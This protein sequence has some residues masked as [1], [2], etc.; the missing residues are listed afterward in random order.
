MALTRMDRWQSFTSFS[1]QV[2]HTDMFCEAA[3]RTTRTRSA[4]PA[5]FVV[6]YRLYRLRHSVKSGAVRRFSFGLPAD[7]TWM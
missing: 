4:T 2:R 1:K 6:K 3:I 7:F 5:G